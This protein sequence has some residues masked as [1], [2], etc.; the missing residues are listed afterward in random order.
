MVNADPVSY[1]E[2][3]RDT[4][5]LVDL[6]D[7]AVYRRQFDLRLVS[8]RA[9]WYVEEGQTIRQSDIERAAA[10]FE[11][12]IYPRVTAVFG[13][14][15]SPG[16]DNDPHL[17]IIHARLRGVGGYYSSTDE[18]PR[19]VYLYSNQREMIYINTA[20]YQVGSTAYLAVLAHELQHAIHWHGDPTEDTWVNEGLSELAVTVAGYR[21][22]SIAQY[23][24]S[25]TVSLLHWPLD[26]RNT[27]AHYGAASLFM[28]Y[29][30]EHYGTR[31]DLRLLVAE[32]ADNAGGIDAYLKTLGYN[33]TFR[34]VFRDWVVAN[35][36]NEAGGVY[37]YKELRGQT[38]VQNFIDR[39][40]EAKEVKS[41]IPQYAV[42]YTELTSFN[43]P[44]RLRFQGAAENALI[45]LE[46][47]GQGCWWSNSGDSINS[48]LTRSI[49]LT[50]LKQATLSYQVW[51][52]LEKDWDYAYVEISVDGGR[53]W[54]ILETPH[55]SRENPIGNGFGPGYT[56]DS[57]GWT[58]ETVDLTPYAGRPVLL[59]F[60]YVT[61]DAVN[62][63]GLCFRQIA[64]PEAGVVEI[65]QGWRANGFVLTN[66]RVRQEYIVQVIQVG[67]DNRVTVIPLDSA[68]SGELVIPNPQE[69]NRLV[70]A[71]AALAP[72]TLQP[73]PYT[74]TVEPAS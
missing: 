20:S 15:W 17:N 12:D 43:G 31:A 55:T 4:F 54:D 59:R 27:S 50:G 62:G 22:D 5:W 18:Y 32:P 8:P 56:G 30:S 37:G 70:V 24:R 13:Q 19:S 46:V 7:L 41:T 60:Q 21:P 10:I 53:T 9:Y 64:V 35:I 14:E 68:N 6:I 28:H 26:Q 39:L 66:N 3:H 73:A 33:V 11:K 69:L 36:L 67:Q 34:D 47:G 1:T 40:S 58:S 52:Q 2:G 63:A 61:D 49:D 72:K 48:T 42:E 16:V 25:P 65:E 23:L 45:P 29:L 71:V 57:S 44:L 51:Y 38:K 74:L